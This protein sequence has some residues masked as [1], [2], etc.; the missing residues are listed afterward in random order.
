MSRSK[1]LFLAACAA[2]LFLG[3]FSPST[4]AA[5]D[6]AGSKAKLVYKGIEIAPDIKLYANYQFN[7]SAEDHANAFHL[8]RGYL[9]MKLRVNDWL[10]SR[11][12]YDVSQVEDVGSAGSLATAEDGTPIVDDSKVQGSL[13]GRVKYAY[14]N[15]GILPIHANVRF[16][17]GHTPWVDWMQTIEGTRFLRKIMFENEYGYPSADFGV[18]FIGHIDEHLSYHLGVYNGEGYSKLDDDGFKD[19]IGRLSLRP[20]PMSRAMGGFQISGYFRGQF[21][22]TE[23]DEIRRHFGGAITYRVAEEFR[24]A[25]CTKVRGDKLAVW[26]QIKTG[27]DGNADDLTTSLGMSYGA[28]VELPA[29]LFVIARGDR[30]DPDLSADSDEFWRVMGVFGVRA[31]KFFHV[32]LNYQGTLPVD[33]EAEHLLGVHTEFHL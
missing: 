25:D 7:L 8:S 5:S 18:S 16:G 9:G 30:F 29:N 4:A 2:V 17:V 14:V 3:T 23:D 22:I 31:T 1:D 6:D 21:P 10:S 28:R 13:M 24:S 19:F 32:A 11:I 12:T 33:R 26:A 27:Q 15:L 20:A